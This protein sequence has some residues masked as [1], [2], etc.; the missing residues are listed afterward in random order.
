MAAP[1]KSGPSP[2]DPSPPEPGARGFP[3]RFSVQKWGQRAGAPR[4]PRLSRGRDAERAIQYR[5]PPIAESGGSRL[6]WLGKG[7]RNLGYD[8]EDEVGSGGAPAGWGASCMR[9]RGSRV[10]PP[11]FEP[12]S[13][14]AGRRSAGGRVHQGSATSLSALLLALPLYQ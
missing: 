1:L 14:G 7:Q 11:L 10:G 2:P 4:L 8:H 5:Y 13:R 12:R 9:F 6:V 3:G